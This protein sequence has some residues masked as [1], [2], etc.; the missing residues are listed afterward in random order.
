M[1][2]LTGMLQVDRCLSLSVS[3]HQVPVLTPCIGHATGTL[4]SGLPA[5]GSSLLPATARAPVTSQHL[6]AREKD[7]VEDTVAGEPPDVDVMDGE[8]DDR[9]Y[10]SY[11]DHRDAATQHRVL[12]DRQSLQPPFHNFQYGISGMHLPVSV[13]VAHSHTQ[14]GC[15]A[16]QILLPNSRSFCRS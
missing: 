6:E 8:L 15:D 9:P 10:D 11:A 14:C 2:W 16:D 13:T 3:V 1:L 4:L 12:P 7:R 5:L